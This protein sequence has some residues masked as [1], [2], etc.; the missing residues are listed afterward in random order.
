[1]SDEDA[2]HFGAPPKY[3]ADLRPSRMRDVLNS[4][5]VTNLGTPEYSSLVAVGLLKACRAEE[6]ERP[7]ASSSQFLCLSSGKCDPRFLLECM[8][9]SGCVTVADSPV[10]SGAAPVDASSTVGDARPIT[11]YR[12][13]S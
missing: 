6:C 7:E 3:R 10:R 9:S 2:Q 13:G 12:I 4:R 11:S 5:V 8:R 1:M